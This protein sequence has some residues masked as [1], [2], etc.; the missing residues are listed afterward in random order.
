VERIEAGL[1]KNGKVIAWR[2]RSAAPSIG[3]TFGA[4]A[5]HQL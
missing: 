1:D 4:G 3:A 2:H 5:V